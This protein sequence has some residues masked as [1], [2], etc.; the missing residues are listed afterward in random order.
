MLPTQ[1]AFSNAVEQIS[2]ILG[3]GR[4]FWRVTDIRKLIGA[5]SE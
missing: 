2:D 3:D 4:F 5:F 1:A